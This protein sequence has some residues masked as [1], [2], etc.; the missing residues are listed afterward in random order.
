MKHK[1]TFAAFVALSMLSLAACEKQ[2]PAERLGEKIDHGV[3][4]VKNG[5]KE[6]VGDQLEDAAHKAGDAASDA[7][8]AAKDA[9]KKD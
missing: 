3:D 8:D 6:P 9:V 4:T 7:A 2:G 5:G 1:I